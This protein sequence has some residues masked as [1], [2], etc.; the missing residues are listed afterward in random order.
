M[1]RLLCLGTA[2]AF[3]HGARG[4]ACYWIEDAAGVVAVDFGPTALMQARRFGC[5]LARLDGLYLTHLHGDHIGGLPVLLVELVYG[6][7]RTR[8]FTIAGPPG[9][10]ARVEALWAA[11]FPSVLEGLPFEFR[12]LEWDVPGAVPALGRTVHAIQ[13]RH[14][15]LAVATSLRIDG[16][17]HR[18]AFSGDTGWQPELAA[19]VQGADLFVCE[20]SGV[21]TGYWGHL[22]VAELVQHRDELQVGRLVVSHLSVESR[23]AAHRTAAL[24]ATVADDGLV[25]TLR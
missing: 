8:P 6:Q 1:T 11:T 23:A 5:D 14:D 17:R 19:L 16:P 3:A 9:T 24:R 22:S 10:Q 7:K 15:R 2:D 13:A 20:C 25:L 4:N 18:L 21:D 12:W